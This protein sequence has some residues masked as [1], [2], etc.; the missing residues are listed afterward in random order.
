MQA[1]AYHI[2]EQEIPLHPCTK[3]ATDLF[4]FE[5]VSYLLIVDYTSR[6]PVVCKLSSMT[7]QHVAKHCKQV[8]SKYGWPE[9]LIYDNGPCYTVDAFTSVMNAYHVNHITS[10]PHHP[11]ANGLA[12][13]Y[14]EIVQKIILQSKRKGKDLFK[15]LMIYHYIH[16]SG[17]LHSLMQILQKRCTRSDLPCLMQLDNSLVYNLRG[18]ELFI[19]MT[20]CLHMI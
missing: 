6:F 16:F 10:S 18:W 8:F 9:T 3:L 7:G 12:E 11:Q 15:C 13:K 5:G 20:I 1:E 19:I 4:Y 2:F 17:S 14:V